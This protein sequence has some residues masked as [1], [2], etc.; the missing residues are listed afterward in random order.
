[1]NYI[2]VVNDSPGED[3]KNEV[4][5][6]ERSDDDH[7]EKVEKLPGGPLGVVHPVEDVG[8]ALEGDALEHGQDGLL[9]VVEAGDAPLW[10]LRLGPA[11]RQVGADSHVAARGGLLLDLS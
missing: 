6:K 9:D 8:P 7:G 10:A 3:T 2:H 11:G 5:D 1:M 4:H